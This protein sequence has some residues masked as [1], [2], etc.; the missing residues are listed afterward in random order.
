[1][2]LVIALQS[3]VAPWTSRFGPALGVLALTLSCTFVLHRQI[4]ATATARAVALVAEDYNAQVSHQNTA[5]AIN[6][7]RI[8]DAIRMMAILPG[9]THIDRYARNFNPDARATAQAVYDNL[10][11]DIALSETYIVPADLEP[12]R[13]DPVTGMPQVPI[14]TFDS[15]IAGKSAEHNPS[16]RSTLEEVEIFEYRAMKQQCVYFK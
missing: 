12:D 3:R 9:I 1:M 2:P 5:V 6:F 8:Y 16:G 11:S 10:A 15:R 7:D 14:P 13:L 4:T